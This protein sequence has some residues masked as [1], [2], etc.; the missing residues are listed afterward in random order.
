VNK[1]IYRLIFT[2]LLIAG[3]V[4]LNCDEQ[5]SADKLPDNEF[6]FPVGLAVHPQ[7]FALVVSSNFDLRYQS[8]S[9][10][11]IDL[12]A[13]EG[14]IRAG[15]GLTEDHRDLILDDRAVGI[16]NF[17]G[18]VKLV[19]DDNNGL[20]MVT[21]RELNELYLIDLEINGSAISFNCW[22]GGIRPSDTKAPLCDGARNVIDLGEDDPFDLLVL[23]D[24]DPQADWAERSWTVYTTFLRS[25]FLKVVDI[26][27][28]RPV[29]DDT[30]S[31][32]H[33]LELSSFGANDL[34][35]SS[36]SGLIFITT[37]YNDSLT[38]PIHYFD[39]SMGA[40][41]EMASQNLYPLFLGNETR[42]LDFTDDGFTAVVLVR[43]PDMLV[44]LDTTLDDS[45]K[46][47]NTFGGEVIVC[48]NPSRVQVYQERAYIT[49]AEDDA[50]YVVDTVTRRLVEIREDICRGP[51][52][53][54]FYSRGGGDDLN[55]L[56][57]TC[58][59]DN[60][61]AVVDVDQDSAGYLDV[62]AR[63]GKLRI[64]D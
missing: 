12:N 7:G 20:A 57:V 29:S 61:V 62:L 41:A 39:P 1:S 27:A 43:N 48:S 49:C 2:G 35:Q 25:E 19:S 47:K 36:A 44:F 34:A 26:P 24:S 23:E 42:G 28:G 10:Q 46:P 17:G 53:M 56:L 3:L 51:F 18:V 55:W 16:P 6:Q 8:G 15:T 5:R 9:L 64:E 4:S 59:E 50:I 33:E 31:E 63:V 13:L 38:N 54:A 40:Q 30:P 37:R 58:F 14:K 60:V 32:T 21:S 22:A 45:G 11:A 52:D